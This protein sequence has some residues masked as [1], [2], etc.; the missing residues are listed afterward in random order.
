M[1]RSAS[2]R[3]WT[4]SPTAS[5]TGFT[6]GPQLLISAR[7]LP[8]TGLV[9]P[10]SLVDYTYRIALKNAGDDPA[11]S[12]AAIT[13]FRARAQSAFPD[14]GW[15]IRDRTDA[16]PGISRFVEQV[17]MFLTLVGLMA[18]GVGGVGA[19]Q[20]VLAFLDRKRADIAILKSLGAYGRLRVP[21]VLPAGDDGRRAG[22]TDWARPLAPPLPFA[23]VWIYGSRLPRAAR[24]S[25]SIPV[26]LLLSLAFGLL[27]AVAFAVP[28]L[29]RA[30]A[31]SRRPACS[32]ILWRRKSAEGQ[33]IYRAL[34]PWPPSA[35][36]R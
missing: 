19:S 21:C 9:T 1:P 7:G 30:P 11:Q 5:P 4:A 22:A 24:A 3:C 32:A 8:A 34:L 28:P 33:N 2:W 20:A 14:A 15:N 29:G 26:P 10:Q 18:L 36:R 31:L 12:R 23:A 16:A 27:S 6:L 25:A 35:S 13:A 17:T